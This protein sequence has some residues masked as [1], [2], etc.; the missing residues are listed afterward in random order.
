MTTE[1]L[2]PG[3]AAGSVGAR[4][5]SRRCSTWMKRDGPIGTLP[6]GQMFACVKPDANRICMLSVPRALQSPAASKTSAVSAEPP[7]A[8][9]ADAAS[10][11]A[12]SVWNNGGGADT[13][14]RV[15]R[16]ALS[17]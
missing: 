6:C 16:A 14:L 12:A 10:M 13:P 15:Q 7:P 4:L 17:L 9:A 3:V 5:A 8:A 1:R 11:L 2:R